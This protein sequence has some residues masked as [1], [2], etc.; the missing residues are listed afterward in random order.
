MKVEIERFREVLNFLS[1]NEA[2]MGRNIVIES[3]EDKEVNFYLGLQRDH[4][5]IEANE[6]S[7]KESGTFYYP[8]RVTLKGLKFLDG[9]SDEEV[10][11]KAQKTVGYF[12]TIISIAKIIQFICESA[13]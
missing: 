10:W 2:S 13:N 6:Y 3:F 9:S 5:L 12:G 1:R 8:T 7:D 4:G 11:E